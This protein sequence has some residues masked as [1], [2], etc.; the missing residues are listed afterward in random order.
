MPCSSFT[1]GGPAFSPS[2]TTA[3]WRGTWRYED[4]R[5]HLSTHER[6]DRAALRELRGEANRLAAFDE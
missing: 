4:G 3:R 1:P 2:G 5:V 6:L